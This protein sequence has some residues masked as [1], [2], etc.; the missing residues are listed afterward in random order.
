MLPRPVFIDLANFFWRRNDLRSGGVVVN[1][2]MGH[3]IRNAGF[4][5]SSMWMHAL[6]TSLK[7]WGGISVAIHSNTGAVQQQVRH[8]TSGNFGSSTV[9]S[10]LA[11]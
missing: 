6:S 3:Q 1:F 5:L 8:L 11:A 7:L 9:P 2:D 4:G 10:K